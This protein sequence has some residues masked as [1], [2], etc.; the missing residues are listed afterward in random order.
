[1]ISIVFILSL[2]FLVFLII[3]TGWLLVKLF[4]GLFIIFGA[5]F[6][7]A[8]LKKVE[9]M[10][11]LADPK[12]G[13]ILYDLGSGDGRALIEA[14]QRYNIQAVGIEINPVLVWLSS[15]KVRK[16]GL[17]DKIKIKQGNFFNMDFSDADIILTYLL[18]PTMGILE[19]KF[20]SELKP[21]TRLVSLAFT[22]DNIPFV[23]S[24]TENPSIRLYK[25]PKQ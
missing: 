3:F 5:P 22:L 6:V 9:K 18:Q 10:L 11:R 7:P 20:L 19:K 8:S 24:D 12:P 15:R 13:E 17:E 4:F 25:I 23:K 21:G 1:M 2:F 16:L 14:A